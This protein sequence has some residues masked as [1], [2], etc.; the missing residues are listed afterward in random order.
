MNKD[1]ETNKSPEPFQVDEFRSEDAEGLVSLFREVYGEAYPIKLFY[2]PEAIIA[3]NHDGRYISII[4]R[5]DSGKVIGATHLYH[6]SPY[7][8]LYESGLGLVQMRYRNTGIYRNFISYIINEYAPQNPHIEEIF[9]ELVCNHV[10]TQKLGANFGSIETAI[11][12]AVMPAEAYTA[13]K[14][15]TG[16]VATLNAF[17]C[18][19]P[20][21]HRI[22]VPSVYDK[23]LHRIYAG[24]DDQRDMV[25]SD[26]AE[27]DT[28]VTKADITIFDF[29][30]VG[31]IAFPQLGSDFAT[32]LSGLE[33]QARSKDVIVFQVWLNLAE[34]SVGQAVDV[35]RERG[36]FFGG[37]LPRWF[38]SDGFLMQKLECQPDFESIVLLSDFSKELL[39]FIREDWERNAKNNRCSG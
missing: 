25:L 37:A 5:T 29:A 4:A 23:I 28:S 13:E 30:R 31:R 26:A 12:V 20:K 2:D 17:R 7:N 18:Y 16:R 24:L 21:P 10:F 8:G 1:D 38:D 33:E 6:S 11:E 15:A 14:S 27:P 3:A 19:V 34:P 9:G 32:R 22:Y 36:Y 39:N 35:L